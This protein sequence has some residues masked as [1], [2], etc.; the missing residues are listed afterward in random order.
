[1]NTGILLQGPVTDWTSDIIKTYSTNFPNSEI[2][3]STWDDENT[4]DISCNIVK[5]SIPKETHP[6]K[7]NANLQIRIMRI[8]HT[9]HSHNS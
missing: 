3:L 1:M 8:S 2:L 4:K 5:T 6:F 9:T 7:L